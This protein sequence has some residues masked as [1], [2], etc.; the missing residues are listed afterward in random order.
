MQGVADIGAGV[1][2]RYLGTQTTE[3]KAS[4]VC[5]SSVLAINGI[6][7]DSGGNFTIE[8]GEYIVIQNFPESH[9]IVVS[10]DESSPLTGK[11]NCGGA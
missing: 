4:S 5:S 1:F 2:G 6:P 9:M 10:V 7:P 11:K 3:E 8:G